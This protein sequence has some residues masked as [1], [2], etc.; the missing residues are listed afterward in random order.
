MNTRPQ[1]RIGNAI[2]TIGIPT[3]VNTGSD[4]RPENLEEIASYNW[5]DERTPTIIVPGEDTFYRSTLTNV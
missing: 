4:I 1:F 5:L 2:A 3:G